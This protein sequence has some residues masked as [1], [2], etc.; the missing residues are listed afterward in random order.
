MSVF[1][2]WA[3]AT[4]L[5]EIVAT[6]GKGQEAGYRALLVIDGLVSVAFGVVLFAR[7]DMGA[8]TVALLFGMFNLIAGSSMLV[9]GIELRRIGKELQ[10]VVTPTRH[11]AAAR[12][13]STLVRRSFQE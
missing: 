9:H 6:F 3:I 5:V 1:A 11:R 7:P 13:L 2:S 8:V 4:G 12:G 10:T